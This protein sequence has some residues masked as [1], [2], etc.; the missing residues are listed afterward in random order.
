M[1]PDKSGHGPDGGEPVSR[2]ASHPLSSFPVLAFSVTYEEDYLLLVRTL[3]ASGVPSETADARTSLS[4]WRE[5]PLRFST[6]HPSRRSW[7]SSG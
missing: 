7:T 3:E 2:E 6:P 4:S 1:F 5:G